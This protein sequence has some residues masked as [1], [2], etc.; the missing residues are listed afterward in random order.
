MFDVIGR[1][2]AK[3]AVMAIVTRDVRVPHKGNVVGVIAKEQI[4][5]SVAESIKPYASKR[6]KTA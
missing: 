6:A 4:A 1:M 5:N 2:W 3:N